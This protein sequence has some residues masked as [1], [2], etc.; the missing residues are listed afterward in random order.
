MSS[1]INVRML[2]ESNLFIDL[3]V[4]LVVLYLDLADGGSA[5]FAE[6]IMKLK[7]K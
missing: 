4:V 6:T 5:H 3:V 2:S 1:W 7:Q